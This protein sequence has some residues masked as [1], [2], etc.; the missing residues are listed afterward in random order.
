MVTVPEPLL[1]VVIP[2]PA[3][4]V[5]VSWSSIVELLPD[6][7]AKFILSKGKL[8]VIVTVPDPLPTVVI[9]VP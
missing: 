9:P 3:A 8:F 7:A 4:I 5:I 2:V 1:V 6:V